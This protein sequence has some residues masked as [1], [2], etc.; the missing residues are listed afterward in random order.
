MYYIFVYIL[1]LLSIPYHTTPY[2]TGPPWSRFATNNA[3]ANLDGRMRTPCRNGKEGWG[4]NVLPLLL[5]V[6]VYNVCRGV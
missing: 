2:H 6:R 3:E 1:K 4:M 5:A